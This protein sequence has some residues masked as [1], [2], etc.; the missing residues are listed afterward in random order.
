MAVRG[1][2]NYCDDLVCDVTCL[3][4]SETG[5]ENE[6]QQYPVNP[7]LCGGI[8][9]FSKKM[10]CRF[11]VSSSALYIL[12]TLILLAVIIYYKSTP[13]NR[14]LCGIIDAYGHISFREIGSGM[15]NLLL[16]HLRIYPVGPL[17]DIDL[18]FQDLRW[19]S[20]ER[21]YLLKND[22]PFSLE[23]AHTN[24][25]DSQLVELSKMQNIFLLNLNGCIL[26]TREGIESLQN[27]QQLQSLY[28]NETLCTD[29]VCQ[30]LGSLPLRKIT[31]NDTDV[32]GACF[33]P[34][35]GWEDLREIQLIHCR[36]TPDFFAG[37]V[38]L[39]S[40]ETIRI[41]EYDGILDDMNPLK[42]GTHKLQRIFIIKRKNQ[43]ED[44][45]D[46]YDKFSEETG[47]QITVI[48]VDDGRGIFHP[49]EGF[50]SEFI[51]IEYSRVI[52]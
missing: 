44:F 12:T 27:M 50:L 43:T 25:Q 10:A 7:Y 13:R 17:C 19:L 28:L 6:R 1:V 34:E 5:H 23:L 40:L 47:I 11:V 4:K 15:E 33:S 32:T 30:S 42:C 46:R 35:Y 51:P 31:L 24:V 26:V 20:F 16:N 36:I 41:S 14:F 29:I 48:V 22:N 21:F 2:F 39:P 37:I 3:P 49:F 9:M 8:I 38:A 52:K 45:H 18:S